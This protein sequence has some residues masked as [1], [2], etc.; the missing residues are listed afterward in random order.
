M[1]ISRGS[2]FPLACARAGVERW[3]VLGGMNPRGIPF[4]A[5]KAGIRVCAIPRRG[6]SWFTY[7]LI[8]RSSFISPRSFA[9]ERAKRGRARD[10]IPS[11]GK[12][13]NKNSSRADPRRRDGSTLTRS[14]TSQTL[15]EDVTI[16]RSLLARRKENTARVSRRKRENQRLLAASRRGETLYALPPVD[17]SGGGKFMA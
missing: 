8:Y 11:K 10:S 2:T 4:G 7:A 9:L 1:G 14:G 13:Q 3:C 5:R 17:R 15:V 16:L 12:R 6:V